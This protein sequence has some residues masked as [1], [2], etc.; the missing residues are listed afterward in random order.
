MSD[1]R[2]IDCRHGASGANDRSPSVLRALSSVYAKLSYALI[3]LLL[4]LGLSLTVILSD[5]NYRNSLESFQLQ[6][7]QVA[8]VLNEQWVGIFGDTIDLARLEEVVRAYQA[9]NPGTYIYF[10]NNEGELVYYFGETDLVEKKIISL[11]PLKSFLKKGSNIKFP[12]FAE[13]PR[14]TDSSSIFSAARIS[15]PAFEGYLFVVFAVGTNNLTKKIAGLGHA[16]RSGFFIV[17][18]AVFCTTALGLLM[19]YII[20]RRLTRLTT[21]VVEF[22]SGNH[23]ARSQ[24]ESSDEIGELAKN[25]DSMAQTISDQ[26]EE[27]DQN[28]RTRRELVASITHDLRRPLTSVHGFVEDM[29][30]DHY[31]QLPEE[32]K[33]VDLEFV[34]SNIEKIDKLVSEFFEY[35]KLDVRNLKLRLS[36]VCLRELSDGVIHRTKSLA[37]DKNIKLS[38][39]ADKDIEPVWGDSVRLERVIFNLVENALFYTREGGKVSIELKSDDESVLISVRD[40]GI[41][42]RPADIPHIFDAFFRADKDSSSAMG[43]GLGLAI[44]KKIVESHQS[45]IKVSSSIGK[46]TCFSFALYRDDRLKNEARIGN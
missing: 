28:D 21:A 9:Q 30:E 17:A 24:I 12:V 37:S 41:G 10:L 2:P 19:F 44:V 27:L 15:S 29:L 23:A 38:V 16:W 39:V 18:A 35:S 36:K 3:A 33:R 42:I 34:F 20:T 11:Q 45:S 31:Q 5:L 8:E 26:L 13:N 43:S 1:S 25:F 22:K 40:S 4:V 32:E 46:G 6:N 7:W 14:A